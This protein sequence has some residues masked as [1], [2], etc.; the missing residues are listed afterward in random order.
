MT[1]TYTVVLNGTITAETP[2]ATAPHRP[3]SEKRAD[4]GVKNPPS[5]LPRMTVGGVETVYFPGSGLR[6]KLRRMA[7]QRVREALQEDG[8]PIFTL[9]D[10]FFNVIG[11]IK[12]KG[13]DSKA[14]IVAAADLRNRNPIISLFGSMAAHIGGRLMIGH[15]VP[16]HPTAPIVLTGVRT[17]DF[18]RQPDNLRFLS[19]EE[20]E[21]WQAMSEQGAENSKAKT[22][23][24]NV[25]TDLRK[26]SKAKGEIDAD[27]VD[28]LSKRRDALKEAV[29]AASVNVKQVLAGY[30]TIPQGTVMSHKIVFR[31]ATKLEIGLLMDALSEFALDPIIGAHSARGCGV[32]S[33]TYNATMRDGDRY[34]DAGSVTI[35]PFEG[36]TFTPPQ[37]G[38][39]EI[40]LECLTEW[41]GADLTTLDF[42]AP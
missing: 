27:K 3:E 36:R 8:K 14:D 30:E 17:D 21:K 37:N 26:L 29:S 11:G 32:I 20:R 5:R 39:T 40:L 23:L 25:E 7:M 16:V 22:E 35:T 2:L 9:D 28:E 24:K 4:F 18:E 33:A 15:A 10:H 41:T 31:C 12:D 6:G 13:S 1:K 42:R 19:E 34:V 38:G